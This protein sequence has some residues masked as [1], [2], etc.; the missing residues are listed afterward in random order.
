M[1]YDRQDDDQKDL[2]D[3][4]IKGL[5]LAKSIIFNFSDYVS[6]QKTKA[7][8]DALRKLTNISKT[9]LYL[10]SPNSV[11]LSHDSQIMWFGLSGY[12][13]FY[14]HFINPSYSLPPYEGRL[15]IFM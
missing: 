4:K 6:Y 13:Q 1:I 14:Q 10:I 8:Y 12:I 3:L 15:Y 5:F 2:T 9:I 7:V 11:Q